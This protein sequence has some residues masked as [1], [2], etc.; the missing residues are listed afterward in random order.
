MDITKEHIN[1]LATK[2]KGFKHN[3]AKSVYNPMEQFVEYVSTKEIVHSKIIASLLN[4]YGE[5]GL[6]MN[7]LLNFLTAVHVN[8]PNKFNPDKLNVLEPDITN[9]KVFT[10]KTIS[11]SRRIDIL[12]TAIIG[13]EERVIVIENKLNDAVYQSNQL[14]DYRSEFSNC[15][16]NVVCIHRINKNED[17]PT[18]ADKIIYA[19]DVANIID[20]TTKEYQGDV[21]ANLKSYSCYLKNI[22]KQNIIMDNAINLLN[23]ELTADDFNFIRS[24]VDAYGQLPRAYAKHLKIMAT[25]YKNALIASIPSRYDNYCYIWNEDYY[26]TK[27]FWVAVGFSQDSASFYVVS[28]DKHDWDERCKIKFAKSLGFRKSSTDS[29]GTWYKPTS[30]FELNFT[31]QGKPDFDDIMRRVI[32]ILDKIHTTPKL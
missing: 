12:I 11:N 32:E 6:G 13:G 8:V 23:S 10:E 26:N 3:Y 5:H 20:K 7:F 22:S 14:E 16:T 2:L 24:L 25:Q 1:S 18:D 4:P 9:V 19:N 15:K 30:N 21:I 27:P 17:K 29:E 31:G 28:N